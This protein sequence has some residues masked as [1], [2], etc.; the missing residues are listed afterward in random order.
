MPVDC[1][2]LSPLGLGPSRAGHLVD[3][4]LAAWGKAQVEGRGRG[5]SLSSSDHCSFGILVPFE[6]NLGQETKG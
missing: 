1:P 3:P 4:E 6:E 2:W 5:Q